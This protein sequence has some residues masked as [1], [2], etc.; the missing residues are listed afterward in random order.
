M[1]LPKNERRMLEGYV[2]IIGDIDKEKWYDEGNLIPLLRAGVSIIKEDVPEYG[3]G[4]GYADRSVPGDKPGDYMRS[5]LNDLGRVELANRFLEARDLIKVKKHQSASNVISVSLTLAGFDLGRRYGEGFWEYSALW[6]EA[7]R[8][9]WIWLI[10]GFLG[11][12]IGG[13]LVNWLSG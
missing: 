13:A 9:H 1:W 4:K 7:Y 11:G 8:N 10:V 3:R 12:I 6:F 5:Y 2:N